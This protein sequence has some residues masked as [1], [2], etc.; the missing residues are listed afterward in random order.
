MNNLTSHTNLSYWQWRIKRG[1][2]NRKLQQQD[3]EEQV[4]EGEEEKVGEKWKAYDN[5]A[6]LGFG[7][8]FL[9]KKMWHGE[10]N[11][12]NFLLFTQGHSWKFTRT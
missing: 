1:Q 4:E 11:L 2:K 12:S 7:C 8:T 10:K 9:Q 6:S 3:E 5:E